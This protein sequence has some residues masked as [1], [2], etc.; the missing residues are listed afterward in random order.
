MNKTIE[1]FVRQQ[2]KDGLVMCNEKQQHV[3]KL[4]YSN[5]N[6]DLGINSVVD[7]IPEDKLDW[8]LCQVERT[9]GVLK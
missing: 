7:K 2:L 5:K 6:L 3:F 4:M 8:A 1:T 9:L